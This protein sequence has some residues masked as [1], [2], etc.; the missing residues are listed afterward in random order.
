MKPGVNQPRSRVSSSRRIIRAVTLAVIGG[1]MCLASGCARRSVVA[2]DMSAETRPGA[3]DLQ[4]QTLFR[5][6]YRDNPMPPPPNE[7]EREHA[8]TRLETAAQ[9]ERALLTQLYPEDA[10]L[11]ALAM[12]DSDGDGVKDFRISDYYGRFLEGDIDLDGD[13]TSN[14][15]DTSP[16][17]ADSAGTG[18]RSVPEHLSW[19]AQGKP[20]A[21]IDVQERLFR[22]HR[23]VLIE[24]SAEFTADLAAT[25]LDAVTR[26]HRNKIGE[27]GL[28]TLRVIATEE[29]S[30]L[31]EDA[32]EGAEDYAQVLPASQTM[33]IY[34]R[35]IDAPPLVQ[36]G[37]LS[38]EISHAVQYALDYDE[39]RQ[40]EIMVDNEVKAPNFHSLVADYGW[41]RR[42][43]KPD[44]TTRFELF[45]PQ[46]IS[47][48]AYEY[49]YRGER[50]DAWE[51]W[52][53]AIYEEV[54]ETDYLMDS[55]ITELHILGDYSLLTPW[56]W[57]SDHVIAYVY[58]EMF[59]ALR[60]RCSEGALKALEATVQTEILAPEWPYFRFAN[61]RGAA[62]QRY[63][64]DMLPIAPED[65]AVLA[66]RYLP[67]GEACETLR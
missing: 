67:A 41:T 14:V 2:S 49:L 12:R 25:I 30:L 44:P 45:R 53:A 52:L 64:H 23:I 27:A 11:W 51:K 50:I 40:R 6:F 19:R 60:S 21:M 66:E 15:M 8:R 13:G 9:W 3:A 1:T 17:T 36:L 56:E 16:Y 43:V 29:S 65:A 46:Y 18:S 61:A 62:F 63:L 28:P 38:H 26:V 59:E 55:R 24:R 58:L 39:R 42:A 32:E 37:F 5:L 22:H 54:G 4:R 48:D 31:Y 10:D 20:E 34:R 35:G 47:S 57:F 7:A 33:E